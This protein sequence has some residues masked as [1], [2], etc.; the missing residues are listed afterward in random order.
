M[1]QIKI[2]EGTMTLIE[3]KQTLEK[4]T[5]QVYNYIYEEIVSKDEEL[6]GIEWNRGIMEAHDEYMRQID[7]YL[8][9]SLKANLRPE[10]LNSD[11]E[12]TL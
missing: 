4:L 8:R 3:A 2:T 10:D 9:E 11:K 1:G 6:L 12:I 7:F 5:D